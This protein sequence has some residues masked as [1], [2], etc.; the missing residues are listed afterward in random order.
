MTDYKQKLLIF[1]T[2]LTIIYNIAI[3]I[4]ECAIGG[5]AAKLT[6]KYYDSSFEISNTSNIR[7]SIDSLPRDLYKDI[8]NTSVLLI[9]CSCLAL[10]LQ[11]G[12]FAHFMM[13]RNQLTFNYSTFFSNAFI[14]IAPFCNSAFLT[15]KLH[16]MSQQDIDTWNLIDEGFINILE[17]NLSILIV[18]VFPFFTYFIIFI[19][20]MCSNY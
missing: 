4:Y 14:V 8:K 12:S 1:L 16:D 20:V 5:E 19:C 9:V 10:I 17:K 18:T 11:I 13:Y 7:I 15:W 6:V 3:G 2:I